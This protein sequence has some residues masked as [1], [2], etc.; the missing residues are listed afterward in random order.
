[1]DLPCQQPMRMT[2]DSPLVSSITYASPVAFKSLNEPAV[3]LTLAESDKMLPATGPLAMARPLKHP[4]E[5][6]ET[7][8]FRQMRELAL[9]S[10]LEDGKYEDFAKAFGFFAS[11]RMVACAGL[12]V[13]GNVFTLECVAVTEELRGKGLGSQLVGALEG[14][15]RNRGATKIWAL[16]RT[17]AFFEKIGYRRAEPSV[18][19]GPNLEGCQTCRQYRV[20]C[21]PSVMLKT[22]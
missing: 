21:H 14:E 7:N 17:P 12:K 22:F 10:G 6:M 13:Q 16:A 15:A 20:N 4:I 9:R 3:M 8:D 19:E 1:M 2:N 5:M 18:S 11:G